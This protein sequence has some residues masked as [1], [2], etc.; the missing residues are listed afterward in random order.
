MQGGTVTPETIDQSLDDQNAFLS[1]NPPKGWRYISGM[2][3]AGQGVRWS[4]HDLGVN[5]AGVCLEPPRGDLVTVC[6]R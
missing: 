1:P 5:W 6:G 2:G 3:D 4:G